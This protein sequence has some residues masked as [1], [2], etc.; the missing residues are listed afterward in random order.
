MIGALKPKAAVLIILLSAIF[1]ILVAEEVL[2][3]P[4]TKAVSFKIHGD[5]VAAGAGL[6]NRG[7][8]D[9]GITGIPSG[10]TIQKAFLYWTILAPTEGVLFKQGKF[11][12]HLVEGT[13]IGS[14]IDPC[15]DDANG[16]DSENS[17]SYRTDVTQYV[18]GNGTYHLSDFASYLTTGEDPWTENRGL[19]PMIEGASLV[20][21]YSNS[22]LP[23]K[24][25]L[26]Y[27]G[28]HEFTTLDTLEVTISGFEANGQGA[29]LTI[30]CADGQDYPDNNIFFN[31]H[32]ISVDTLDGS[33]AQAGPAFSSGNLWDT[34]IYDVKDWVISGDLSSKVTFLERTDTGGS[35]DC[36]VLV[37]LV[38]SVE[39]ETANQSPNTKI[40]TADIDSVNGTAK[41]TWSGS[42]D[43]TPPAQLVYK[44][45]LL[46]PDSPIYDWWPK[47]EEWSSSTTATY[48]RTPD[49]CLPDGIYRFQVKAKDADG[50]IQPSSTTWEF[51]IGGS[52]NL[53]ITAPL[54]LFSSSP[55]HPYQVGD[56]LTATFSITNRGQSSVTLDELVVGG[57]LAGEVVDFEKI[58]NVMIAS[59]ETYNYMGSLVLQ[60]PGVYHFFC[61]YHT[62][63]H[64]PGEDENNWNTR[65][66]VEVDGQILEDSYEAEKHRSTSISVIEDTVYIASP[67]PKLWEEMAGPWDN[68]LDKDTKYVVKAIAVNPNDAENILVVIRYMK[69]S[70]LNWGYVPKS[71]AI[72]E[73]SE[74]NW[75]RISDGLPSGTLWDVSLRVDTIA[76]APSNPR[77]IYVGGERRGVY[78][79][80]NGGESWESLNG[81]KGGR[82][83]FAYPAPVL[84]IAVDPV[85]PYTVY[86][87]TEDYGFWKKSG[88]GDWKLIKE[89]TYGISHIVRASPLRGGTVYAA[90]YGRQVVPPDQVQ[91][92]PWGV[93]KSQNSGSSWEG[94]LFRGVV[95]DIAIAGEDER[96]FVSTTSFIQYIPVL[97]IVDMTHVGFIL[98][99]LGTEAV[100][101]YEGQGNW[102]DA[103][104]WFRTDGTDGENPLPKNGP[105]LSLAINPEFT[106]MVFAVVFPKGIYYSPNSG[107]DWFPIGFRGEERGGDVARIVFASDSNSS[108]LYAFGPKGLFKLNLADT[109][110]IARLKSPGELCAH[111]SSG[112]KTGFVD[113]EVKE[114]LPNSLYYDGT[115]L[116]LDPIATY[117][118]TVEGTTK[119]TYGLEL[120]SIEGVRTT[121]FSATNVPITPGAYH[122]YSI[123]WDA[124][125]RGEE[126]VT[127][128]IDNDGDGAF[129]KTIQAG[130]TLDGTTT[131]IANQ[132]PAID[133]LAPVSGESISD[134]H[135]QLQWQATDPDNQASS[136]LIDL[137]YSTNGGSTWTSISSNEANDGVYD[138]D[139]STLYG[140]QYWLKI[141]AEDPDG[142]TS[143]A[144]A[145][146]FTIS[147]FEGNIIVGPNPVTN[148]GT[149]FFYT[150]PAGTST[151]KLMVFNA[152]GRPVFE[153]SLDVDP[154]RFPETGTW[155][156]VDQDGVPL[157]NGPY[158]YVLIADGRAIGQG[159]MVI[160]R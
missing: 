75:K 85:D 153:T 9:I 129:E 84:S 43:S 11:D 34:D 47:D 149:A 145:G 38:L 144:T 62:K 20:V 96:I 59:G 103:A 73:F 8:G 154:S 13:F 114:Q 82:G 98:L 111:D 45:R 50:A 146:P 21:I 109:A 88:A 4:L 158:V 131:P 25:I 30:I 60:K 29:K 5:Y 61:A 113:G 95:A 56:S 123:D 55:Y 14:D 157:A 106:N 23:L 121:A 3:T 65:I 130:S 35:Y 150:L 136:L 87:G 118:Y 101:R 15:W 142:G 22:N 125:A 72:Y 57:R 39:R 104:S 37:A 68:N 151:A 69:P 10:S 117:S 140:G 148:T 107:D 42:D 155:D 90:G 94:K 156:P 24:D 16:N 51:T 93:L 127:L 36:S 119:G 138:W 44:H 58:Y 122:K 66:D 110:L 89:G 18:S 143:E 33:D 100:Y 112:N 116:I 2:G 12:G 53:F 6:R 133:I 48:P 78:R 49:T 102:G 77:I 27:E 128:E 40:E 108:I 141:V 115:V 135:Y 1:V 86:V 41:F 71:E 80:V 147:V 28:N 26:V 32:F 64:M 159:K 134:P 132:P 81:P 19:P 97:G 120:R 52:S 99:P 7:Y 126:G 54:V 31:D 74:G 46:N 105:R 160:Q 70:N 137:F 67:R 79:S 124:L 63:A 139:I 152:V 76:L 17:W 83:I 91:I 92:V